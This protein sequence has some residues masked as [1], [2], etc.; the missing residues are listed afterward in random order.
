MIEKAA[1]SAWLV[2]DEPL[3]SLDASTRLLHPWNVHI[4]VASIQ[5]ALHLF[6]KIINS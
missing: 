5:L 2:V 6:D 4:L 3:L 1:A